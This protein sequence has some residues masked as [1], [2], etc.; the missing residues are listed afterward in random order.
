LE[1]NLALAK[2]QLTTKQ[3]EVLQKLWQR[4]F[5][6]KN[7]KMHISGICN[8][9]FQTL[10]I[11]PQVHD[12]CALGEHRGCKLLGSDDRGGGPSELRSLAAELQQS[13]DY[14]LSRVYFRNVI[15]I[16]T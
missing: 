13:T 16:N 15:K 3:E 1:K 14:K 10:P 6:Y 2:S 8:F 12:Q 4:F 7:K 11:A 5:R 9:T